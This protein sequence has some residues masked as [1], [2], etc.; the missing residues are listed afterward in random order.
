MIERP[1]SNEHSPYYQRYIDLVPAGDILEILSRQVVETRRFLE[2]IGEEKSKRRYAPGKW[3]IREVVGHLSDTERVFGYRALRFS[4]ND[5]T[6]LPSFEQ[7][8]FVRAGNADGRRL[9]GLLDEFEAV[10]RAT[11]ALYG[12]MSEE[13]LARGG[14]A[15]GSY[16]SV[17]SIPFI[18][19]GHE[20]HHVRVIREKY[21]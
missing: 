2:S 9:G 1:G 18:A 19:A 14:T 4:R 7:D 17:R 15:S 11:L 13:M 6:P 8:D 21:L 10:R 3:S 5:P 20:L 16:I 12:G